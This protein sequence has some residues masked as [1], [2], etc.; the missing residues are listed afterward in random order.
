MYAVGVYNYMLPKE[1]FADNYPEGT[2]KDLY[3]WVENTY[4]KE[5]SHITLGWIRIDALGNHIQVKQ[6]R[7]L[8]PIS[9]NHLINHSV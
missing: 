3:L 8:Y 1:Y 7:L 5:T 9:V 6:R 4:N 2:N